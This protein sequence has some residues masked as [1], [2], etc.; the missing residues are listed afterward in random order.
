METFSQYL[1]VLTYVSAKVRHDFS[2]GIKNPPT[3]SHYNVDSYI[4]IKIVIS[5]SHDFR[6]L[7]DYGPRFYANVCICLL[8][9]KSLNCI[10]VFGA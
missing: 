3:N 1:P 4:L 6:P 2:I 8:S 10:L 7:V 9:S 5:V